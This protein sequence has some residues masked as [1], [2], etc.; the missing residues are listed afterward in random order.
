MSNDQLLSQSSI[1]KI[2]Y[3]ENVNENLS[4]KQRVRGAAYCEF[5]GDS[6]AKQLLLNTQ[7]QEQCLV[8]L[9]QHPVQS[10]PKAYLEPNHTAKLTTLSVFAK[11]LHFRC[12]TGV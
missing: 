9:V 12:L 3:R 11:E 4:F 5:I 6:F 10:H 7:L 1:R 8:P 2:L